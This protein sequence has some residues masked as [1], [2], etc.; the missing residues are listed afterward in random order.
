MKGLR[1]SSSS[2]SRDEEASAVGSAEVEAEEEEEE[3]KEEEKVG[4]VPGLRECGEEEIQVPA[5]DRKKPRRE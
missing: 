1:S 5:I 4:K 2:N 3:G